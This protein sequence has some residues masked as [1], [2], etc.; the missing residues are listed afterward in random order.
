MK[1]FKIL[2]RT[3]L[4]LQS[5]VFLAACNNV[6][7][8]ELAESD[9]T[10]DEVVLPNIVTIK[11][12]DFIFLEV[13]DTIPSGMNTFR[14]ENQGAFPHN[15]GIARLTGD[16]TYEEMIEY[17]ENNGHQ[18]PEWAVFMG[19][20]SAPLSGETSEA[21]LQLYPGNYALICG[22]P[23]PNGMPHFMKGMTKPLT[24]VENNGKDA[25]APKEDLVLVMDDYSFAMAPEITAGTKTILVKNEGE[26]PHEFLLVRL[27]EEKTA[28]D[29][30]NWLGMVTQ[31]EAG[32][33]PAAPGQFLNG[34][35]P[36][37]RGLENYITVDFSPGEYALVCPILDEGDGRPH[38]MHGMVH[39]FTVEE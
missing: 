39:Q 25:Q 19:G 18:F 4:I 7:S 20:P 31:T 21:T 26:Q 17:V 11:T 32:K 23:V 9:S 15:A 5:L 24:V 36:M 27:E 37:K 14:I 12:A 10:I 34:V 6:K 1:T 22:V 29:I 8:N 3:T 13:P 30:L 2:L 38:F 35:S 28:G 33:L 16:H